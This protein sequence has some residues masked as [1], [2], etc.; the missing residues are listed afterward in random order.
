M[1]SFISY[2]SLTGLLEKAVFYAEYEHLNTEGTSMPGAIIF[3][4]LVSCLK[5]S[6]ARMLVVIVSLGYG[7]T[8]Y[9]LLLTCSRIAKV[10]PSLL[11]WFLV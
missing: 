4:E 1:Q 11:N 10:V 8:R 7:I 9:A 6:L 5:R 3:A 2:F